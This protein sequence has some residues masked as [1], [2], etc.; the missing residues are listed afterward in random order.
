MAAANHENPRRALDGAGHR[1][2]F[3]RGAAVL[4]RAA[5]PFRGVFGGQRS[6][7]AVL[8]G[9]LP[10]YR[11]P[12]GVQKRG[13]GRRAYGPS[14]EGGGRHNGARARR[15]RA[16]PRACTARQKSCSRVSAR[17]SLAAASNSKVV[18]VILSFARVRSPT[19]FA[20]LLGSR[21][22]GGGSRSAV[23][24]LVAAGFDLLIKHAATRSRLSC[25]PSMMPTPC[26]ASPTA[27]C[28]AAAATFGKAASTVRGKCEALKTALVLG[29]GFRGLVG[30]DSPGA[31]RC[32]GDVARA[33]SN[34]RRQ[35]GTGSP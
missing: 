24:G 3:A 14:G 16:Q 7:D 11:R 28:G 1:P 6:T 21:E 32:G 35:S 9:G 23:A 34:F 18:L 5:S 26:G 33:S 8:E 31:R 4:G 13:F 2:C 17:T 12:R 15:T 27:R 20:W 30:G 10:N 25:N 22:S 29:G 19:A